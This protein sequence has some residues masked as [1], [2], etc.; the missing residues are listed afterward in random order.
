MTVKMIET[1]EPEGTG[2][3][4]KIRATVKILSRQFFHTLCCLI[5]NESR[6]SMPPSSVSMLSQGK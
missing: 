5:R 1:V 3:C 4:K 2:N 6:M